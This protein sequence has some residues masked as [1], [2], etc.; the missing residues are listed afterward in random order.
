MGKSSK[1]VI[2]Q[3]DPVIPDS[4]KYAQQIGV[5]RQIEQDKLNQQA[6]AWNEQAN[7]LSEQ[8][9]GF[10]QQ[11]N[12]LFGQ[13]QGLDMTADLGSFRNQLNDLRTQFGGVDWGLER[14]EFQTMFNGINLYD[15]NAVAQMPQ[16]RPPIEVDS[17]GGGLL[18]SLGGLGGLLDPLNVT[19]MG[20][21]DGILHDLHDPLGL[22]DSLNK[23]TGSG[24]SMGKHGAIPEGMEGREEIMRILAQ[25]QNQSQ[26]PTYTSGQDLDTFQQYQQLLDAGFDFNTITP[27][28][29]FID[30]T[31]GLNNPTL[32]D[33][34]N[35]FDLNQINSL[36]Q[37]GTDYL[38]ELQ[39]KRDK[40]QARIDNFT[41]DMRSQLQSYNTLLGG[42]DIDDLNRL[43]QL[44]Q[45]VGF[46]LEDIDSF[47]SPLGTDFSSLRNGY[48]QLSA[49][50]QDLFGQRDNE[51]GRIS[52]FENS[53][54]SG[55]G[56]L[57]SQVGNLS[58]GDLD[59]MNALKKQYE[60]RINK[61]NNFN[62]ELDFDLSDELAQINQ[63]RGALDEL[64]ASRRAEEG[65]I[66]DFEK[67]LSNRIRQI[68]SL[69]GNTG[70]YNLDDITN[71]QNFL[72]QANNQMGE[73]SSSLN[74]DFGDQQFDMDMASRQ[75]NN[76]INQRK[77]AVDSM[78]SAGNSLATDM[79]GVADYDEASIRNLLNLAKEGQTGA[80]Q[81]SGGRAQELQDLYQGSIDDLNGRLQNIFGQRDTIEGD[82]ASM[83]EGA[84]TTDIL[85]L[86]QLGGLESELA[87]L[88]ELKNQ[89]GAT[90]AND[91][92]AALQSLL[93]GERSRLEQDAGNVAQQQNTAIQEILSQ[94][95][96]NGNLTFN[97]LTFRDPMTQS[98]YQQ[99]VSNGYINADDEEETRRKLQSAFARN[100]GL[101]QG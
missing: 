12:N 33:G 13:I 84:R 37:R 97:D 65:R 39:A 28:G 90:Q 99:L 21:N 52:N 101:I 73:F 31:V 34:V 79:G 38:N 72:G 51:F 18:G 55:L 35:E 62:S 87:G 98:A 3:P 11:A 66:G 46:T 57:E 40:E 91:E 32:A 15:T 64:F 26:D 43:N 82:L 92:Y 69:A 77:S 19:G 17:G 75:I 67:T 10:N 22:T 96:S 100:L 44:Q 45:N 95:D 56:D 63:S 71:L 61:A 74:Y 23:A 4:E 81:F 53:L 1:T 2:N 14:P 41:K 49:G 20:S 29:R 58:I 83:L 85:D 70:I 86:Q 8:F 50:V 27:G 47:S 88:R 9:S 78:F 16:Q 94:L 68:N 76:L 54:L 48:D 5:F 30:V 80:G 60:D 59:Q 25:R 7:A 89:W 93:G 42:Y 36:F 6:N 24:G